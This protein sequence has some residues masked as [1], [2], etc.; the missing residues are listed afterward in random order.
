MAAAAQPSKSEPIP[1][2]GGWE[3]PAFAKNFPRDEELDELV[4]AFEEGNYARVRAEAPRLAERATSP[5]VSQAAR[6]LRKRL[7]PDPLAY[8]LLGLTTALLTFL[9][10]WFLWHGH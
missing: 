8:V 3:R 1:V 4:R 2:D 6:E 5:E 10:G 7:D 9:S